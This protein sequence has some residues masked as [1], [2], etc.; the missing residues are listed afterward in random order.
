M[1]MIVA[2]LLAGVVIGFVDAKFLT[3]EIQ[4]LAADPGTQGL[5]VAGVAAFLGALWGWLAKGL[6]GSRAKD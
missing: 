6:I 4:K 1:R 5:L 3:S 2:A